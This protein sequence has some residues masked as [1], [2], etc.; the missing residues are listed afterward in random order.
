MSSQ[1]LAKIRSAPLYKQRIR[2]DTAYLMKNSLEL[3]LLLC[4]AVGTSWS[5]IWRRRW[6]DCGYLNIYH[7]S[8]RKVS[9]VYCEACCRAFWL[10]RCR[11][12]QISGAGEITIFECGNSRKSA[13][14]SSISSTSWESLSKRRHYNEWLFYSW[15][16]K[17]LKI[18]SLWLLVI[19]SRA[20]GP[21]CRDSN[22]FPNP[23]EFEP[24]RYLFTYCFQYRWLGL[25]PE[26]EVQMW[27]QNMIFSDGPR[28]CI[29]KEYT[30][31]PSV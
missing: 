22:Q 4:L 6:Y 10:F 17:S 27:D 23:E 21:S 15:R 30:H 29:G 3:H 25:S 24:E 20:A 7:V 9:A 11:F 14:A 13:H 28:V 18:G 31:L 16:S 19:V 8:P 2:T 26:E 12:I 1:G 5:R